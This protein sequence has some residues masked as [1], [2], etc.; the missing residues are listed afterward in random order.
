MK[1]IALLLAAVVT[2]T[3]CVVSPCDP[4]TLTVDWRFV[5]ASG[6]GNLPCNDVVAG[7]DWVDVFIDGVPSGRVDCFAY[8]ATFDGVP[9]GMHS[10]VVEGIVGGTSAGGGTVVTRDWRNSQSLESCG[11]TALSVDPGQADLRVDYLTDLG[12]CCGNPTY[13]WYS[14]TDEITGLPA[15]DAGTFLESGIGATDSCSRKTSKAC[16]S[17]LQFTVPYG[18]Y[19][20]DWL[21][22]M[23]VG[24][25]SACTGRSVVGASGPVSTNVL[26]PTPTTPYYLTAAFG[27]FGTCL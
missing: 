23:D 11:D 3:G 1:R 22:E 7:A 4:R 15:I 21:S 16:N 13:I 20:L 9:S 19:T 10:L 5:D 6:V 25:P 8:G 14:L 18:S 24:A 27:P 17:S 2:G 12:S 26:S